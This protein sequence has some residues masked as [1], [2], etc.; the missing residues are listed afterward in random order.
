[1]RKQGTQNPGFRK[2]VG[3]FLVRRK[4]QDRCQ[5]AAQHDRQLGLVGHERDLIDQRSEEFRSLGLAVFA[6]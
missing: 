4:P 1:M 6:L 5:V 2:D 3:V